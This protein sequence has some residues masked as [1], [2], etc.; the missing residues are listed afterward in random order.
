MTIEGL[1]FLNLFFLVLGLKIKKHFVK[2]NAAFVLYQIHQI[3][4]KNYQLMLIILFYQRDLLSVQTLGNQYPREEYYE[5][6]LYQP[7]LFNFLSR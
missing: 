2:S 4:P 3:R 1:F 7:A 6:D 5:S